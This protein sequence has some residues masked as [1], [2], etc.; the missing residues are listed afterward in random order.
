MNARDRERE[1]EKGLALNGKWQWWKSF[2]IVYAL[3]LVDQLLMEER[4]KFYGKQ[5]GEERSHSC[6]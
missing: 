4:V 5:I 2:C 6:P 3:G 1:G